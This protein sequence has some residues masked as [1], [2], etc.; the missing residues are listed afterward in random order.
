MKRCSANGQGMGSA[1]E[2]ADEGDCEHTEEEGKTMWD[3]GCV[4]VS[5]LFFAIAIA[6][7]AGCERLG[8]K[9]GPR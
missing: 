7:V 6:Y 3:V 8:A 1:Q 2:T 5:V 4:A 9:E